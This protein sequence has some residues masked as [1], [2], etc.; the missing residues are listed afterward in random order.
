MLSQITSLVTLQFLA[1]IGGGD[2]GGL[3]QPKYKCTVG[4]EFV[5]LISKQVGFEIYKY[6]YDFT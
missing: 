2:D 3:D 6:L 5:V 4:L 1:H